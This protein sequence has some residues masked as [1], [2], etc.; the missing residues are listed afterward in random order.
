MPHRT[1]EADLAFRQRFESR[2]VLPGEFDHRAH[3][4]LAYVYLVAGSTDQAYK[5]MRTS[6]HGFLQHHNIAA[7]KYHDTLTRAWVMAVRH[8]MEKTGSVE[9]AD[10]LMDHNPQ[11]LDSKI[12]LTHYSAELL[13]SGEARQRFVQPDIQ[14]IPDYDIA[15]TRSQHRTPQ[16]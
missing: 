8:F 15:D 6:L 13:F 4:R 3:I 12:M 7:D 1:S 2:Q 11:M 14:A 16:D 10:E 5:A 9:S